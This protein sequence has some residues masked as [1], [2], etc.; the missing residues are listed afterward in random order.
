MRTVDVSKC[1][2]C[3][4]CVN[5]CPFTPGRALWNYE[6]KHAQKCDLCANTPFW[7]LTLAVAMLGGRFLMIV[8]AIAIAGSMVGKKVVAAGPGTFPTDGPTFT[9]LLVAVILIV[10]ALTF[11][12]ALSL[13]P[14]LEHFAALGGKVF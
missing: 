5:A 9:V 6:E 11:F 13:G 7:N 4:R 12:P 3:E 8:P 2:G 1:I 14:V 10:G